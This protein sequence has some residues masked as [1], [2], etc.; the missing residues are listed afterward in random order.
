MPADLRCPF[1]DISPMLW[2]SP[3]GHFTL[4][5]EGGL[6]CRAQPKSRPFVACWMCR[7]RAY[8]LIRPDPN[9]LS[10]PL[11]PDVALNYCYDPN[12]PT[13]RLTEN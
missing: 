13:R 11:V 1:H 10:S 7:W 6:G 9:E 8:F 4:P 2:A 12:T 3:A 5:E